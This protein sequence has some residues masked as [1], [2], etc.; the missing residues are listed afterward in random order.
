M[1]ACATFSAWF[2]TRWRA[3]R[4]STRPT[5]SRSRACPEGPSPLGF[6]SGSRPWQRGDSRKATA[7]HRDQRLAPSSAGRVRAQL[8]RGRAARR[9]ARPRSS[10]ARASATASLWGRRH[11]LQFVRRDAAFSL[12]EMKASCSR[13]RKNA[14]RPATSGQ[15]DSARTSISYGAIGSSGQSATGRKSVRAFAPR[16][17]GRPGRNL[18]SAKIAA[19]RSVDERSLTLTRHRSM[20]DQA[21]HRTQPIDIRTPCPKTWGDLVGDDRRRFCAA[22]SLHVHNAAGMTRGE[23]ETLVADSTSRVCMRVEYDE[24]GEPIFRD[25]A[26]A[27]PIRPI[28]RWSR[29]V[30]TATASVLAACTN[31]ARPSAPA[32]GPEATEA[33]SQVTTKMGK[34]AVVER[35]GE[36]AMPAPLRPEQLGGVGPAPQPNAPDAPAPR[37]SPQP[38]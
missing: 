27:E 18:D 34:V 37:V 6:L 30:L 20:H 28:G 38:K 23:A 22:C 15:F 29:W 7:T 11:G 5:R 25:S 21:T 4:A 8:R 17:T 32:S 10:E 9:S 1:P 14:A 35:L 26:R 12:I 13:R 2:A 36:V 19:D 3:E 33:G 31:S 24:R 16:C